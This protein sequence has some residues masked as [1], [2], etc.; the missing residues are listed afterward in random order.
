MRNFI[1]LAMMYIHKQEII[2]ISSLF[3]DTN[4]HKIKYV[5]HKCA[6]EVMLR[7]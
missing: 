5:M 2:R 7:A 4:K 1:F 6:Q 3:L